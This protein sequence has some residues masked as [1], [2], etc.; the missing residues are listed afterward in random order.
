MMRL[1][2]KTFR[3]LPL[4]GEL[5]GVEPDK[6]LMYKHLL[7]SHGGTESQENLLSP[8]LANAPIGRYTHRKLRDSRGFDE[9]TKHQFS[10]GDQVA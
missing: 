8:A 4:R 10:T 6:P 7:S 1:P 5:N 3:K 9:K 2:E